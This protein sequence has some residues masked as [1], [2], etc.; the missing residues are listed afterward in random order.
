MISKS[1]WDFIFVRFF[2]LL[3]AAAEQR[4]YLIISNHEALNLMEVK[5]VS[6]LTEKNN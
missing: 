1:I 5:H 2:F 3:I 6:D 4:I